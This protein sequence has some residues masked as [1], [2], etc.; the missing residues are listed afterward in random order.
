MDYDDL[1]VR[2]TL[3]GE[4][5]AVILRPAAGESS[6]DRR[7][8]VNWLELLQSVPA[9]RDHSVT[10]LAKS[11]ASDSSPARMGKVRLRTLVVD[12]P[13][14]GD[15][16]TTALRERSEPIVVWAEGPAAASMDVLTQLRDRL[17]HADM[18]SIRRRRSWG[19]L[20]A[21]PIERLVRMLL[22]IPFADPLAPI[23]MLRREAFAPMTFE[24]AGAG[25]HLE[26]LAKGT[27][28]V[29]LVDEVATSDT[30]SSWL[31]P[32]CL[33]LAGVGRFWFSPRLDL[34]ESTKGRPEA[35]R[36]NWRR[37]AR[38]V[39][40]WGPARSSWALSGRAGMR[41]G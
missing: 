10:V 22:G 35:G 21:W 29:R 25:L 33:G 32:I 4:P 36:S 27:Y 16:L 18:V 41:S 38:K 1:F 40:F 15:A 2:S 20:V 6:V 23:K 13:E 37:I 8:A 28:L 9:S 12:E 3:V 19:S 39:A 34:Q 26:V 17:E 11:F 5:I 24:M 31:G 14:S 30:R 7:V